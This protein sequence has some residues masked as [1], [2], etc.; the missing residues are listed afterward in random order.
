MEDCF[1]LGN[2]APQDHA[3]NTGA[4]NTLENKER[5]WAR[6]DSAIVI[7]AGPIYEKSD[8][9]RIGAGGVRVPGAFF[10]ALLAPYATTPRAIAFVYPNMSAPGNMVNYAMSVDE[11]EKLTGYDFFSELPDD[12]EEKVESL[13][14]FHD[15]ND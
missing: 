3:L 6:R 5:V 1:S 10:K 9:K 8:T 13:F 2:M 4:W 14:S 12:V 15:W 7:V 11:L